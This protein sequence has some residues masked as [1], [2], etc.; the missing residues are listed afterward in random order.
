MVSSMVCSP[1]RMSLTVDK[2]KRQRMNDT[3]HLMLILSV[4]HSLLI[5]QVDGVVLDWLHDLFG[6]TLEVNF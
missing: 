2:P 3:D 4:H 6:D 5:Q 1:D